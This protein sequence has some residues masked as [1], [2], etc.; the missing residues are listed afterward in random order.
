MLKYPDG[1]WRKNKWTD[2]YKDETADTKMKNY[3]L[4]QWETEIVYSYIG[5]ATV[6]S[7]MMP[8]EIFRKIGRVVIFCIFCAIRIILILVADYYL[9]ADGLVLLMFVCF[10]VFNLWA[11]AI[12][13]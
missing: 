7:N 4:F 11:K 6:E 2:N 12:K 1:E 3:W 13:I 10:I 8:K 9:S 5:Y